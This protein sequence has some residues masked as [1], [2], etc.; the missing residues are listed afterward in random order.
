MIIRIGKFKLHRANWTLE[1]QER[2]DVMA[3]SLRQLGGRIPSPSR[4]LSNF[5][6]KPSTD[7]MKPHYEQ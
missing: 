6:L 1:A 3:L 4:D 2:A 5:P 7:L